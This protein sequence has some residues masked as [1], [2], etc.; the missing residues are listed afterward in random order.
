MTRLQSWNTFCLPNGS[1]KTKTSKD[2][3][4]NGILATE[5]T[6]AKKHIFRNGYLGPIYSVP[7]HA[8]KELRYE[9]FCKDRP[10]DNHLSL[11]Q[12]LVSL[13][14]KIGIAIHK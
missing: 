12:Q 11:L 1:E 13:V 2:H 10:L 6:D 3:H 5:W 9:I 4:T 7:V 8:H 14:A